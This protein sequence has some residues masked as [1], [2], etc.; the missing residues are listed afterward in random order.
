[1]SEVLSGI[2]GV[3][4]ATVDRHGIASVEYDS[5]IV[6]PRDLVHAVQVHLSNPPTRCF[7]ELEQMSGRMR[8]HAI[9][10]CLELRAW[11]VCRLSG[12]SF[13]RE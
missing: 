10:A 12:S 1:M 6:G 2:E 13:A 11:I 4:A 7:F 8:V 3:R 9:F 5:S